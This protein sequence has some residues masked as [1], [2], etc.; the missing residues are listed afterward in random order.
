MKVGSFESY[1]DYKK[2]MHKYGDWL[3]KPKTIH[4]R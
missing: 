4:T 1:A 2:A 3:W